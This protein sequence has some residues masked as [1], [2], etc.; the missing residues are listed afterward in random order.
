MSF[1]KRLLGKEKKQ[2]Q[3]LLT[4]FEQLN[5]EFREDIVRKRKHLASN[6]KFNGFITALICVNTICI[7]LEVDM[8]RGQQL[9]DRLPFFII[10]FLFAAV[11]FVEML[12]RLNQLS[13]DYFINPWNIFDYA[14]VVL[15]VSDIVVSVSNQTSGGMK[16]AS[17]MRVFRLLRVVRS[18]KGLKVVA[19]LWLIIQGILD[20]VK[21]VFWVACAATV[22]IFCFAVALTT[23][24]GLDLST[25]ELWP[26]ADVYV[27]SVARSMLT[28][29][30]VVT[31]DCWVENIGRPLFELAPLGLVCVI[32]AIVILTFGTLNILVAVMVER[33]TCITA[34]GKESSH[35]ILE[36]TENALLQSMAEEFEANDREGLGELNFK[37]FRRMI[38]TDSLSKKLGLLGIRSTDAEG[39]F[40]LMD[41]DGSGTITPSEFVSG[42]QKIKGPAKG[43]DVVQLIC[44]AQKQCVRAARFV[45]RLRA[46]SDMADEIQR[47]L[48]GVGKG[49]TREIAQ[50]RK[51]HDRN[52]E[53]WVAAAQ[54]QL[55]I[56]GLDKVRQVDYPG[57]ENG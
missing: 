56:N 37:E 38:R 26:H 31:L 44:F 9:S 39:L 15:S 11:F 1:I 30:Q 17:S 32:L 2:H 28:V 21:T 14:L 7:G 4:I 13:W 3:R 55:V 27:G 47:R 51:A 12:V 48:Y 34:E 10:E 50:R 53:T 19:G 23:I 5:A 6:P 25:R 41:V 20:S 33:I 42:L 16:L 46:L 24:T 29:L 36:K 45:E 43:Q 22:I 18:I 49:L 52:D 40:S 57:L 54:R 8:S 35:K